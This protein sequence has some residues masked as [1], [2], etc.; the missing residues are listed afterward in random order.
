MNNSVRGDGIQ[1]RKPA[2]IDAINTR[3]KLKR[4]H[5]ALLPFSDAL[6]IVGKNTLEHLGITLDLSIPNVPQVLSWVSKF[7]S[8]KKFKL[9]QCLLEGMLNRS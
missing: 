8:L 7:P 1:Y 5:V 9:R 6:E 4:M 3:K 2:L